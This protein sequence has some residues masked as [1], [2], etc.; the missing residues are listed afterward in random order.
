MTAGKPRMATRKAMT[1]RLTMCLLCWIEGGEDL[2]LRLVLRSV[3]L[4]GSAR[5]YPTVAKGHAWP[6]GRE[7]DAEE[8]RRGHLEDD[9]EHDRLAVSQLHE[10]EQAAALAD[11]QARER[12]GGDAEPAERKESPHRVGPAPRQTAERRS[13]SER[14]RDGRDE[15]QQE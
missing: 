15:V 11:Q 2:R 4:T 6:A 12:A 1:N 7:E 14:D 8:D 13:E 3:V 10:S 9:R 5:P